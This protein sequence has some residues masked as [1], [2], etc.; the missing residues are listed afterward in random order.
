MEG[1]ITMLQ[2][3]IINPES[4][5]NPQNAGFSHLQPFSQGLTVSA[6]GVTFV[7]LAGQVSLDR[8]GNVVGKNDPALQT[9][10]TLENMKAL[11]D[12]AGATFKDVVRLTVFLKDMSQIAEVQK[13]RAEFFPHNPPPSTTIEVSKFVNDDLLIEIE[14]TALIS[15]K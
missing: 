11:L 1:E 15:K 7:F 5:W 10:K 14:A 3:K 6:D 8:E 12:E 2:K 13:V 9:R 4:T